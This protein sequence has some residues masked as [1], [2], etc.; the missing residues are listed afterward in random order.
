M[1]FEAFSRRAADQRS[2]CL[3][4]GVFERGELGTEA[5]AVDRA[6]RGRLHALLARGDLSGRAGETLLISE[7]SGLKSARLL[8]VGLGKK[9]QFNRRVWRRSLSSAIVALARTRVVSA[10]LAL[11]RPTGREL[12]DYYF[13]RAGA[14][15]TGAAL[16]SINDLKSARRPRPPALARVLV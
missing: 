1:R 14:E 7:L 12:N 8:L 10:A 4:I 13:G 11:E 9:A 3:V 15:L 5:L 2:D 16:Y 6:M